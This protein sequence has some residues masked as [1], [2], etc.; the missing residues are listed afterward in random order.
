VTVARLATL[1]YFTIVT[2]VSLCVALA[3]LLN[4]V[5]VG[6]MMGQL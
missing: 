6:R 3:V 4:F 5:L 1:P 2:I